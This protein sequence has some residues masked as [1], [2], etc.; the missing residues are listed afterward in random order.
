VYYAT[1]MPM[2]RWAVPLLAETH[3]GRPTKLEGNPSYAPHGGATSLFAQASILDLYDPDRATAHTHGT[4]SLDGPGVKALLAGIGKAHAATGG[5]GLA[6][7]ADGSSSL[8]RALLTR[9]LRAKFPKSTWA[10]YEP[11]VDEPPAEAAQ[12]AFLTRVKPIY[13]FAK[14]R[15]IV[16]IDADFLQAEAGSLQYAREFAKGRRVTKKEDPMNRLYM[17]ES[18]LSITG[19]M[20]DHRLRLASGHMFAFAAALAA[21]VTGDATYAKLA[22]GTDQATE[23]I[24]EC[25]ADLVENKGAC[26]VVAGSHLP[27]RSIVPRFSLCLLYTSRCV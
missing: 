23:W 7:L 24:A 2:R 15:R 26:L 20:A 9:Y 25:A 14:A 11:V 6:F 5:A 17:A 10:E 16:S 21:K 13:R 4:G 3:Q 22:G 12:A 1:A 8:T 19:T 27:R 18:G